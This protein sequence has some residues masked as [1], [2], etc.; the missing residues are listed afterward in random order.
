MSKAK[1][2]EYKNYKKNKKKILAKER[3]KKVA[4]GVI[5]KLVLFLVIAG[6]L[7]LVCIKGIDMYADY[8]ASRPDYSTNGYVLG[9][10]CGI[11]ESETE[12][13]ETTEESSDEKKDD[14]E[15]KEASEEETKEAEK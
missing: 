2:E 8:V 14:T 13:E 5:G 6:I 7:T 9:D 10:M 4:A 15:T 1:V 12:A 3:R 11:N